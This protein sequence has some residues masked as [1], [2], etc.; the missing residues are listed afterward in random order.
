MAVGL[1]G[2]AFPPAALPALALGLSP[3]LAPAAFAVAGW[4]LAAAGRAGPSA[5]G[6]GPVRLDGRV[7]SVPEPLADRVRFRLRAADGTLLDAFAPPSPWPLAPGDEVRLEATLRAPPGPRN[8]GGRDPAGRLAAGG[9]A[10]QA[11]AAGPAVRTAPPSPLAAVAAARERFAAAADRALPRREA[12]VVR[13][14]GTGDR[15]ALDRATSASFARSGLAHVLAVS[16]L[17]LVVVALGLER[18]L[19]WLLLRVEPLA[20]RGDPRRW[21]AAI[22]LPLLPLY[23]LATGAGAPVLRSAVAAA[24]A[25]GGALLQREAGAANGLALAL[26]VLLAADPG[27]ALDASLQ[28]SFAAVA[29]L[30]LWS[31]PLRRALPVARP[32]RGTRRARLVE[33]LLGGACATVAASAATAPV[34]AFHFRQLPLLGL[35]ANVAGVPVGSALTAV[36]AVAALAAAAW[37]PLATPFLLAARPLATALLALSDAAAAPRWGVLGV[38]S[39]GLAGAAGFAAAALAATRARGA[40]RLAAAAVAAA[41]LVAPG[42]LR[43]A[44]ARAR[45]GLEVIFVSVG[46]GDAALLRLPDGSAVLVDAGGAPDGGADPGARDVVPLLR[47]LGVRRLAAVFVSHPHPDHVLGLAAVAEAFPVE[48][49]LSNGDGG[50]GEA[51]ELLAAL[52]PATLSPGDRWER[53]GVLFEALGGAREALA[54]NDASLVLRV[55][56]GRTAFLFPGDVEEAGEAAAVA[57]G[58]L[59]ADVVKVPHHASRRSST[60]PFAAAVRP[61]FAVVS[62]GAGNR[63]GFPH[64]EALARWRAVGARVLRTDE[65]AVRL[66]SDGRTVRHLP[67]ESALDPLAILRERPQRSGVRIEDL[68]LL[69]VTERLRR[70]IPPNDPPVGYLRGRSWFRDVLVDELRCSE[71]EAEALVDTLEN[72]GYIRFLGDTSV[73]A[74]A[75]SRWAIDPHVP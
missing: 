28:L 16:G 37:P 30:A 69:E 72:N 19:R 21:S 46:Q 1:Q 44:A 51:R 66:L 40:R 12:A 4:L 26:L 9:V 65:G 35:L 32:R 13:A 59:R 2:V 36:S 7:A 60:A 27:A 50:D 62:L 42:P 25:L 31:G 75:E 74:R 49:V 43:A 34:L 54:P 61:R 67:A 57:R 24:V 6:E 48:R 20:A 3:P 56:Y 10:L 41:C 64:E 55:A 33:P 17:H 11:F 18:L 39:P 53:A 47:D 15:A 45:G 8:P 68:D 29:G 73:R 22:V 71:L 52:A 38:A 5:A 63:Y 14:I 23:A 70:R 58:G